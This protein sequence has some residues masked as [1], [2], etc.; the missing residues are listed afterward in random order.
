MSQTMISPSTMNRS[1]TVPVFMSRNIMDPRNLAPN[2]YQGAAAPPA[3]TV[4]S[5]KYKAQT[6]LYPFQRDSVE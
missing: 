3:E 2:L 6:K 4:A 5:N 1:F